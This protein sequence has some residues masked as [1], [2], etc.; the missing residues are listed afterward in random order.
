MFMNLPGLKI[1]LPTT[2]YDVKGL[3]K[4]ALRDNNPV[5][6]FEHTMLGGTTGQVPEDEYLIPFGKAAIKKPGSD[7]TLVAFAKMVHE[8]MPAAE[9]L[10]GEGISVEVIDPRTLVPLDR[11]TIL[12]SVEKTGRLVVVDE[13]CQTCG[14]AAEIIASV[15]VFSSPTAAAFGGITWRPHGRGVYPWPCCR[16]SSRSSS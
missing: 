9:E 2:P 1:I 6:S 11:E 13:A 7:V 14:V 3:L 4:T 10:A 15:R 16:G 5:I 12:K 8:V